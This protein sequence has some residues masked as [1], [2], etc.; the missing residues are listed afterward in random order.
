M[1]IGN[2][3]RTEA[4]KTFAINRAVEPSGSIDAAVIEQLQTQLD[5]LMQKTGP[6][7]RDVENMKAQIEAITMISND[8]FAKMRTDLS[9]MTTDLSKVTSSP[10]PVGTVISSVVTIAQFQALYGTFTAEAT[11]MFADGRSVAGSEYAKITGSNTV[12]DLRGAYLRMAGTNTTKTGWAGGN[13]NTYAED[14][15]KRP[16]TAFT[17]TVNDP[18]VHN[19]AQTSGNRGMAGAA[20]GGLEGFLHPGTSTVSITGGGDAETRPKTYAVNYYIKIN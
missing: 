5:A 13:I 1:I 8:T 3:E 4:P 15:T 6:T 7:A 12:P 11:W 9:K 10:A 20:Q 18:R 2:R 19:P 17:G 16:T 14:S